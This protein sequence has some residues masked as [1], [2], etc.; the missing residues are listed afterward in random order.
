MLSKLK[1]I[2]II[3]SFIFIF[4]L[5][6]S[7]R[8]AIFFDNNRFLYTSFFLVFL[9]IILQTI[10]SKNKKVNFIFFNIYFILI[11]NLLLTPIFFSLTFDVP[12]RISNLEMKLKYEGDFFKGMR[13]GTHIITSDNEGNR[14]NTKIDYKKKPSNTLRV[15][16]IGGSTTMDGV[17]DD[18]K[19]WTNLLAKKLTNLTNK[20]VE[21]INTGVPGLRAIHHYVLVKKIKNIQPDLIIFLVGVNDWNNHITNREKNYLAPKVEVLYDFRKSILSKII[22]NI[23]KQL[24]RK[25]GIFFLKKNI[26]SNRPSSKPMKIN[27]KMINGKEFLFTEVTDKRFE[28]WVKPISNSL[29]RKKVIDNFYPKNVSNSYAIWINKIIKE[30]KKNNFTCVFVD[31]PNA[32]SPETKEVL[33][34]RFWMTPPYENYTLEYD[35]LISIS[36]IYNE[37]LE[38]TILNNSMIFCKLSERIKPTIENFADDVHFTDKGKKLVSNYLYNCLKN[39][40]SKLNNVF[41]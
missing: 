8:Q 10:R 2:L 16:A 11:L 22:K 13:S 5:F 6:L 21:V 27:K 39:N 15:V 32:Y 37:W 33:K 26:Q 25:L 3:F 4:F 41:N 20:K 14:T 18:D 24:E 29:M 1:I 34:K 35:N 36:K 7:F 19:I 9:F 23:D 31:Q 38:I 17:T 28:D 40:F 30:C 12:K